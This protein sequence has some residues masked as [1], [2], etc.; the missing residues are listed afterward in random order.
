MRGRGCVSKGLVLLFSRGAYPMGNALRLDPY[1][2]EHPGGRHREAAEI[3]T[4]R[5]GLTT[6][7][8]ARRQAVGF[9]EAFDAWA[10]TSCGNDRIEVTRRPIG[11]GDRVVTQGA[12]PSKYFDMTLTDESDCAHVDQRDS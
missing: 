12:Y 8:Y 4:G 7:L 10:K 11:E 1:L 9:Q 5:A 6:S 3:Q 2:A